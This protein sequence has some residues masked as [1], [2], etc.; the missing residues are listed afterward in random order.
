MRNPSLMLTHPEA[1]RERL[2]AFA[3]EIP[4]AREGLKI[5]A[6]LLTVEGQRPGW[7]CEVLGLTRQSLNLWMHKVNRQGLSALKPEKR[8]GRPARLTRGIQEKLEGDLEKVPLEFGLN[9]ARWDGPTLVRHL[10]RQYGIKLKVRQAQKGMHQLGYRL[11]RASY[12]YIRAQAQEAKSFRRTL[13]K[14]SR[15][16]PSGDRGL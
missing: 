8:P 13:K 7:V 1:S 2:V 10:E 14:T 6:L 9:R 11:K 4:G 3:R 12:S 16:G 5:A 15:T